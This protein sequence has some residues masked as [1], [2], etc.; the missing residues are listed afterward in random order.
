MSISGSQLASAGALT[1]NEIVVL[2]RLSATVTLTASTISF[3][4]GDDSINHSAAGFLAAG[5]ARGMRVRVQGAANGGNNIFSG[6]IASVAA[7]K[8]TIAGAAGASLVTEAAGASV[9]VTAW[10]SVRT[11]ASSLAASASDRSISTAV[12]NSAGTV[13][14]NYALGDYFTHVMTANVTTLAFSNLPG[15]GRGASLMLRITQ[16]ATPRTFAW[17][18]SFKWAGG[19]V[20]SLSTG[21]G[22]VDVL[23]ITTFDNGATWEA[24]L[25][26]A[27][28]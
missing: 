8:L 25:T 22:V 7:G 1:G 18:A 11:T 16:D 14:L 26:K 19:A 15:A 21:S 23:S 9:T 24:T 3:N 4:A 10:Q 6:E 27:F 13:T 20:P 17:P 12:A 5:F 2:S 28:A